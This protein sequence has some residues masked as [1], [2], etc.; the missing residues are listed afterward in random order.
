MPQLP[1]RGKGWEDGTAFLF[2]AMIVVKR[3]VAQSSE[4]YAPKLAA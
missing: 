1:A 2:A 4:G 3:S